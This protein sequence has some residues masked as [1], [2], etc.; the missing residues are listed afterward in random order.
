MITQEELK[1]LFTYC[2][3]T[4]NLIRKVSLSGGAMAGDI[5]GS[6]NKRGYIA[7]KVKGESYLLHRVIWVMVY[8]SIDS[9]LGIDHING[10]KDDNK[11]NN[12]RLVTQAINNKNAKKQNDNKSG[13]TGV[14][15]DK[16]RL[17]WVSRIS[18]N[19]KLIYLGAFTNIK[20]AAKA[21]AKAEIKYGFHEN[22]GRD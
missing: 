2:E 17:K 3:E 14:R 8:G 21:R 22:H 6:K 5:A 15:W 19:G 20:D 16:V 10:I 7:V 4:G 1:E 9:K 18:S 12:L 11:I 13:V